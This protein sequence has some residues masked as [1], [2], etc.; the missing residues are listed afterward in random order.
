MPCTNLLLQLSHTILM[1]AY[2]SLSLNYEL[3]ERLDLN[4]KQMKYGIPI[5]I[6]LH[7]LKFTME[8]RINK[9]LRFHN[10]HVKTLIISFTQSKNIYLVPTKGQALCQALES[11]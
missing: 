7:E 4:L 5:L 11:W 8:K 9:T 1:V 3:Y 2:R 10:S 6:L